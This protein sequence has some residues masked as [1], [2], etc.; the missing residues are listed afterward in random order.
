MFI[1]IVLFIC[2]G[3]E[4]TNCHVI[5]GLSLHATFISNNKEKMPGLRIPHGQAEIPVKVHKTQK[6]NNIINEGQENMCYLQLSAPIVFLLL[7]QVMLHFS[8]PHC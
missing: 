6:E 5:Q 4:I 8:L 7:L 3:L 1:L 2:Q